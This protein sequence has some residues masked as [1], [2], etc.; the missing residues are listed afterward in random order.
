[1]NDHQGRFMIMV[2]HIDVQ[3]LYSKFYCN[4]VAI[5]NQVGKYGSLAQVMYMQ[6]VTTVHCSTDDS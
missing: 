2:T 6:F 4:A 5:S 1:M 3:Q